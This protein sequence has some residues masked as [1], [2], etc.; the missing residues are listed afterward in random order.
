MGR[1]SA[2]VHEPRHVLSQSLTTSSSTRT[3]PHGEPRRASSSSAASSL[4]EA[5]GPQHLAG[6]DLAANSSASAPRRIPPSSRTLFFLIPDPRVPGCAASP[7]PGM[8]CTAGRGQVL[9]AALGPGEQ[10]E[11]C[12]CFPVKQEKYLHYT[13]YTSQ[14]PGATSSTPYC[15]AWG[16]E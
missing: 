2:G 14:T 4:T 13:G 8:F 6:S 9:L 16:M 15:Q 3:A 10:G 5:V 12:K 7:R 1:G 11:R